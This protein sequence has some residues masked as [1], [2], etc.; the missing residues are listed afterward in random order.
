MGK[1]FMSWTV[2]LVFPL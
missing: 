2:S 1:I